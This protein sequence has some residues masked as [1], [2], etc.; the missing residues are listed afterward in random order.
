MRQT[1]HIA[2]MRRANATPTM[3]TG[4]LN[5]RFKECF[6]VGHRPRAG[7]AR[8]R[9]SGEPKC[10]DSPLGAQSARDRLQ[11]WIVVPVSYQ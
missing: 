10:T 1:T 8:I 4:E 9:F 5:R 7:S 11:Y 2:N 3:K 6:M